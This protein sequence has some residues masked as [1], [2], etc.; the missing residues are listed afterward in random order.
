LS[1]DPLKKTVWRV[2]AIL[3]RSRGISRAGYADDERGIAA[4]MLL[5]MGSAG[6]SAGIGHMVF[7]ATDLGRQGASRNG[8][9]GKR[10]IQDAVVLGDHAYDLIVRPG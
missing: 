4:K 6:F 9:H 5:V 7:A 3:A 2:G 10:H 1:R 8:K